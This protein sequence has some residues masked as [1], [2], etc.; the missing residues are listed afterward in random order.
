MRLG[1]FLLA[2]AIGLTS[3]A[4]SFKWFDDSNSGSTGGARG[5]SGSG[6][7]ASASGSA[8]HGQGGNGSS[9]SG[10][11][12]TGSGGAGIAAADCPE[13]GPNGDLSDASFFDDGCS[14]AAT[15]CEY[16]DDRRHACRT[17]YRCREDGGLSWVNETDSGNVDCTSK[18]EACEGA[19][20]KSDASCLGNPAPCLKGA[21]ELTTCECHASKWT[22]W[23]APEGCPSPYPNIGQ[24][25]GDALQ[26]CD[27][28][29]SC[30]LITAVKRECTDAGIWQGVS[31]SSS[32]P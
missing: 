7:A 20:V 1:T 28:A 9:S 30:S 18:I 26:G 21:S 16:G 12:S 2:T 15:E 23:K 24:A 5:S 29:P 13:A 8:G 17:V 22:C 25:C 14:V 6:A 32:P 3:A 11:M 19:P 10:A 31:C 27:Y 4:C